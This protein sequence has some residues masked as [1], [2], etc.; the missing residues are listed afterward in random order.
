M[1]LHVLPGATAAVSKL[2]S[3]RWLDSLIRSLTKYNSLVHAG[4]NREWGLY[5]HN[6]L[7]EFLKITLVL[8]E[9]FMQWGQDCTA[10]GHS[11]GRYYYLGGGGSG[12]MMFVY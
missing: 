12:S 5:H 4:P 1:C 11:C 10:N 9:A 2:N 3:V 7:K 6:L 8:S